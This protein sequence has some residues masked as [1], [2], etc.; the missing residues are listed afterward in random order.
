M[1][2]SLSSIYNP[3]AFLTFHSFS[4]ALFGIAFALTITLKLLLLRSLNSNQFPY[5]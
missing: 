3:A 2:L 1:L 5:W 4:L